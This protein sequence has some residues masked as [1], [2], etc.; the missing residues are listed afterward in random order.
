MYDYNRGFKARYDGFPG[1]GHNLRVVV[2]QHLRSALNER[3]NAMHSVSWGA[4]QAACRVLFGDV[5]IHRVNSPEHDALLIASGASQRLSQVTLQNNLLYWSNT[6]SDVRA[7]LHLIAE[8]RFFGQHDELHFRW[9]RLLDVVSEHDSLPVSRDRLCELS[10]QAPVKDAMMAVA[11]TL[12]FT[13]T[14]LAMGRVDTEE[15]L[16]P[17]LSMEHGPLL[18]GG[19]VPHHSAQGLLDSNEARL[20]RRMKSKLGL[21]ALLAGPTGTGK[22]VLARRLALATGSIPV[23]I[24]GRDGLEDRDVIGGIYPTE[25]GPRWVDGP[26]ARAFR[27]AQSGQKVTLI[28]EEVMRLDPYH[29]NI[30]IGLM[31]QVSGHELAVITGQ[32]QAP[33]NYYLLELAGKAD[34]QGQAEVLFAPSERLSILHT[35]N[36]GSAYTQSGQLDPALKR[37]F[38]LIEFV[39]YPSESVI[40]PVYLSHCALGAAVAYKLEVQT[41]SMTVEQGQSLSQPMNIGVTI[42]YLQ[43]V[44]SLLDDGMNLTAAL[45][46]A[47]QSTVIPFCCEIGE[48]GFPDRA[49]AKSLEVTLKR[50]LNSLQGIKPPAAGPWTTP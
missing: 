41:R 34:V 40:M 47:L 45:N 42:N 26:L 37:R 9:Q 18:W 8:A 5:Q 22:S 48:D 21:R 1:L 13:A 50:V 20:L 36:L 19:K 32:P 28:Q 29:R 15:H 14:R 7:Y 31:D 44:Q 39:D 10:Y 12:Y 38:Q 27:I 43:E 4:V 16:E 2:P 24:Q 11:D 49:A 35:T 23:I 3:Q 33:G 6:G 25:H 30:W 17:P 46:E